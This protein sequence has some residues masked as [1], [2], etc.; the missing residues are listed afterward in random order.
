MTEENA[1]QLTGELPKLS[2]TH[3]EF[4]D[5]YFLREVHYN[6]TEAYL[7]NHPKCSRDTARRAASRLMTN[8]DIQAHIK[9][10]FAELHQSKD[11]ILAQFAEE[12]RAK[13]GTF[14]KKVDE[15][16]MFPRP[17]DEILSEEERI[18]DT[19]P[20]NPKSRIFYRV[21]R[22]VLDA[23]KVLDPK[24]SHLIHKFIDRG[25]DGLTVELYD[26]Q[27]ARREALRVQG[28]YSDKVTLTT[29][30]IDYTIFDVEELT[31]ITNGESETVV[32]ADALRRIAASQSKS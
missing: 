21:V 26:A 4:V 1:G 13:M 19:D 18:D 16:V 29:R 28:A 2:P 27:A 8:V 24:Y 20:E 32:Y 10:R 7:L 25:K 11:E 23:D 5:N 14:F 31:R 12:G 3:A 30:E 9:A 6:Q 22:L 17:T 15:W